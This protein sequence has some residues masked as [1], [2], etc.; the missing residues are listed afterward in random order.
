MI[1]RDPKQLLDALTKAESLRD[2]KKV[3]GKRQYRRFVVRGEA[4]LSPMDHNRLDQLPRAVMIRDVGRAGLGFIS[5]EPIERNSTWRVHFI[6]HGSVIG[7]QAI[8]V[9]HCSKIE[10]GVY[11]IGSQFCAETGLL[12]L[13]GVPHSEIAMGDES[14][15]PTEDASAAF[16]APGE[17]A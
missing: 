13:L 1:A 9:R 10:E 8:I 5:P 3:E 4:E 14:A 7:Q 15:V 6:S 17:V 11:L 16:L 2:P 12:C